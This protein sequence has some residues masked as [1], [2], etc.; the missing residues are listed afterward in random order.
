MYIMIDKAKVNKEKAEDKASSKP[1]GISELVKIRPARVFYEKSKKKWYIYLK[2]KKTYIKVPKKLTNSKD[3]QSYIASNVEV[4]VPATSKRPKGRR[5][6]YRDRSLSKQTKEPAINYNKLGE[7][8]LRINAESE[9]QRKDLESKEKISKD[10]LLAKK[11]ER[12]EQQR[13]DALIAKRLAAL[14]EKKLADLGETNSTDQKDQGEMQALHKMEQKEVSQLNQGE[15]DIP[16]PGA[17]SFD[18]AFRETRK[19]E[20]Q[21]KMPYARE[22]VIDSPD[23]YSEV[24]AEAEVAAKANPLE[25]KKRIGRPKVEEGKQA[26]RRSGREITMDNINSLQKPNIPKKR[27]ETDDEYRSKMRRSLANQAFAK[28][29]G[30]IAKADQDLLD[31]F[32]AKVTQLLGNPKELSQVNQ[33]GNGN[34]P[35]NALSYAIKKYMDEYVENEM[36]EALSKGRLPPLYSDEIEDYFR[37]QPLFSGVIASDQIDTLP[38]VIPQ[39]FIMNLDTS[40]QDGSHWVAVYI[41]NDSIEYF[42]PLADPPSK[43]FIIDMKNKIKKMNVPYLMKFKI[44]K[45]QQQH[46]S[47]FKCGYHSIR[48]LDDRFHDIPFP[49]SSRYTDEKISNVKHGEGA[50]NREF[51][52]I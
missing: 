18:E 3:I 16:T 6:S 7:Y 21:G 49:L 4:K 38:N 39:G 2:G 45:I 43:E 28:L 36:P 11:L 23:P 32:E 50:V 29:A 26:K 44:N 46:G 27:I 30:G 20:L 12:E 15:T 41:N 37:N 17:R 5:T 40:D 51:S 47:S 8:I 24:E 19:Q 22:L 35:K 1:I 10:E 48:F 34:N 13:K 14:E 33:S 9:K 42:D 31:M 25:E 52:Y